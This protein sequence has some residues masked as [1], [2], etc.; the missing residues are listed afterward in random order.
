MYIILVLLAV[1]IIIIYI[2]PKKKLRYNVKFINRLNNALSRF[3]YQKDSKLFIV[4]QHKIER[5]GFSINPETFQSI[6]FILPFVAVTFYFLLIT[7]N[8]VNL[9]LSIN[10]LEIAAKVLEDPSVLN[11]KFNVNIYFILIV[12]LV[13]FLLPDLA[14]ILMNKLRTSLSKRESQTLQTYTIILLKTS[15]PV[16]EILN[17]L[18]ERSQ[19]F[20]PSLER[21]N[22]IF[23]TDSK[24]ALEELKDS[25]PERSEFENICIALHQALYGNRKLSI[26]YLGNHRD[27][28][29]EV[30]KQKRIRRQTRNQGIGILVLMIPLL[31]SAALVGYPWL[32]VTIRA[33]GSIPI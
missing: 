24:K 18:Y 25:A 9:R 27:L 12:F 30:N 20:R 1:A 16:K 6:R 21:A 29:R 10:E 17:S 3:H 4:L 19:Y 22:N 23:S 2:W 32:M 15:K 31:I 13:S 14:L 28:A 5:A 26:I 33:I 11:V 8:Y 7:I